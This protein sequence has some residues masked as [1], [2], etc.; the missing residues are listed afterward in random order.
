MDKKHLGKSLLEVSQICFGGNVF[1]WTVDQAKSFT[2]LDAFVEAGGNFID[3]ADSYSKWV[4]GN[5]GGESE[6]IIGNWMKD[7]GNRTKIVIA[8]KVGS[9]LAPDKK[10][11]SKK[12]ILK[13]VEDSLQ[14]LQTD[15]IDLYISHFP[16]DSTP[17]EETLEA[18]QIL[19][20]QGKIK[21]AGASNYSSA[22]LKKA[23]EKGKDSKFASYQS[24]QPQYNLYSRE[25]FEKNLE[26]ICKEYNLGVTPYYSLASGFLTGKYRSKDDLK[27][28]AR[29]GGIAEYLNDRGMRILKALDQVSKS[30]DA[31]ITAVSLAWLMGRSVVTAPIVSATSVDQMKGIIA[32]TKLKLTEDSINLL[33]V[34]SEP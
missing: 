23:C 15:Y 16:D 1:G 32:S 14:R 7:R 19:I 30:Q 34:A 4:P 5:K 12:Y 22:G 18:Y 10:G 21:A 6:T 27:K 13:A 28:S 29:G 3:T 24:L 26:P 31:S 20:T 9:E 33:N 8:T 17:I 11:L 25:D 2:L